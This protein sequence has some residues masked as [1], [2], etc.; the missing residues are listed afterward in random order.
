MQP[1]HPYETESL[2]EVR[3]R[4]RRLLRELPD[5]NW[6]LKRARDDHRPP[7]LADGD[8]RALLEVAARESAEALLRP[9]A[10]K[11]LEDAAL[12]GARGRL[13]RVV[14][15][16]PEGLL[17]Q[18]LLDLIPGPSELPQEFVQDVYAVLR[19]LLLAD[20]LAPSDETKSDP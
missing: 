2:D 17:H 14:L 19:L 15:S 6:L 11:H 10:R 4:Q 3:S 18:R 1:G 8:D 20:A 5:D 12:A 16:L 13:V 7:T 9:E